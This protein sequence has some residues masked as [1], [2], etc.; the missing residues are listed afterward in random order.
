V[1]FAI[2]TLELVACAAAVV[3]TK[4][5]ESPLSDVEEEGSCVNVSVIVVVWPIESVVVNVLT[6]TDG[7]LIV[8]PAPDIVTGYAT[9]TVEPP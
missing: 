4:V 3:V 5:V 7:D 8:E 1:A 2:D 9:V 6:E